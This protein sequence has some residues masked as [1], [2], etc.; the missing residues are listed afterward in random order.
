MATAKKVLADGLRARYMECVRACMEAQGEEIL[1][2]ASN[3][4][5]FPCVDAEGNEAYVVVTFKVPT[6]SRDGDP[7]D[8]YAVAEDYAQ[9]VAEAEAKA[10]AQAEAKARKMARDKAERE[11]KA[12]AKAAAKAEAE[13]KAKAEAEGQGQ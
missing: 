9:H 3:E 6:G 4:F 8:G 11:A 10:K 5:A 12:K 13:A 7:Y 1:R 2:T